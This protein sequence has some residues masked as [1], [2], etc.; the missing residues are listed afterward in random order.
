MN[1]FAGVTDAIHVAV[2]QHG[3]RVAGRIG[4]GFH[5]D[6]SAGYRSLSLRPTFRRLHFGPLVRP[7][8]KSPDPVSVLAT[9]PIVCS[10]D[11]CVYPP[12]AFGHTTP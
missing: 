5:Y 8:I 12:A 10:T 7:Y 11:I 1:P 6:S 2:V 4:V 9:I 3:N